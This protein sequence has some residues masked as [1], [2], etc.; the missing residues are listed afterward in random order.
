MA[1]NQTLVQMRTNVRNLTDT[2]GTNALQRHPNS[3]VN[4]YINRAIGSLYRKLTEAL[5][6][7]RYLSSATIT[8]ANGTA[9]YTLASIAADFDHLI[10]LDLTINGVKTWLTAFEMHERPTLADTSTGT[11]GIPLSYMLRGGTLEILP[12]P[13]GVYTGT[14]WYV[15]NMT[16]LANDADT[17][18]T[19]NRLDDYIIAYAGRLVAMRDKNSETVSY[20]NNIIAEMDAEIRA[21]ARNRDKNSPP[22]PVDERFANRWGRRAY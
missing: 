9:T 7:Q 17:Y 14:L 19:I 16:S 20:C 13:D 11:T 8:T 10:S 1:L 12:T 22:R 2:G 18:D 15:P 5:P 21:L 4:D 3:S 6:A